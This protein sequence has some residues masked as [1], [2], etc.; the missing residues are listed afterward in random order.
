MENQMKSDAIQNDPIPYE[1]IPY[2]SDYIATVIEKANQNLSK[3][4]PISVKK[5]AKLN[6]NSLEHSNRFIQTSRCSNPCTKVRIGND[7]D[8]DDSSQ[9]RSNK[10]I[11]QQMPTICFDQID[12][13][14]IVER[15]S[16]KLDVSVQTESNSKCNMYVQT[17]PLDRNIHQTTASVG[18]VNEYQQTNKALRNEIQQ[19]NFIIEEMSKERSEQQLYLHE[20]RKQIASNDE[21]AKIMAEEKDHLLLNCKEYRNLL[22]DY[23]NQI[24]YYQNQMIQTRVEMDLLQSKL[25]SND[26][27]NQYR[28]F[29]SN[30]LEKDRSKQS[31]N[32]D[33]FK[34]FSSL[35][36]ECRNISNQLRTIKSDFELMR[37]RI[38]IIFELK[39]ILSQHRRDYRKEIDQLKIKLINMKNSDGSPLMTEELERAETT[40][41]TASQSSFRND[42]HLMKVNKI[43]NEINQQLIL[44]MDRLEN[45]KNFSNNES[46]LFIDQND[47]EEIINQLR[48]KLSYE[49]KSKETEIQR[50]LEENKQLCEQIG[51]IRDQ[52]LKLFEQN[53]LVSKLNKKQF[54]ELE[55]SK[56]IIEDLD[57]EK[58]KYLIDLDFLKNQSQSKSNT[59]QLNDRKVDQESMTDHSNQPELEDLKE[60]LKEFKEKNFQLRNDIETLKANLLERENQIV[61]SEQHQMMD[62]KENSDQNN[63]SIVSTTCN[64]QENLIDEIRSRIERLKKMIVS[65]SINDDFDGDDQD[66]D[67]QHHHHHNHFD[68]NKIVVNLLFDQNSSPKSDHNQ[69]NYEIEKNDNS[70]EIF[71]IS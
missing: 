33:K 25:H 64:N 5:N 43:D 28:N 48:S 66:E 56:K 38:S 20:I 13:S 61:T 55:K 51:N 67:N 44:L 71:L 9:K 17:I 54:E 45:F 7:Y 6:I 11:P 39:S 2:P 41:I 29:K 14:R 22:V 62:Q 53:D 32:F 3:S 12:I 15:L 59:S 19:L 63:R 27:R 21:R 40:T 52:N 70:N 49:T 1:L 35:K 24:K 65:N 69:T 31:L 30:I 36:D 34:V 10:S 42:G 46:N 23:Q 58:R 50:L 57:E 47:S 37:Q 68:V 18:T 26:S 8:E 60:K 16:S 4:R